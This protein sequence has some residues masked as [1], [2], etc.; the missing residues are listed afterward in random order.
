MDENDNSENLGYVSS[1]DPFTPE[2]GAPSVDAPD[3]RAL[4]QVQK[5]LDK[6]IRTYHTISGMK[7]FDSQKFT[8]EEREALCDQYTQLLGN[9]TLLVNN[10]IEGIK[11]KQNG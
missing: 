5:V 7:R 1:V 4:V 2:K 11:E 8:A 6:E 9:L 10:A 3:E